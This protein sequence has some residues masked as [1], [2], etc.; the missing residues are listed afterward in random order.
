MRIVCSGGDNKKYNNEGSS[1]QDQVEVG[2]EM[3]A[4]YGG[5]I[6]DDVGHSE[7]E[8]QDEDSFRVPCCD[9]SSFETEIS[10][11]DL[12]N[13]STRNVV[14]RKINNHDFCVGNMTVTRRA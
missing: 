14:G 4:S 2:E 9:H 8:N 10:K 13:F 5:I 6:I 7:S 11:V 3:E 1:V 12:I